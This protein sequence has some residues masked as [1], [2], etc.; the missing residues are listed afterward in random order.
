MT[1]IA[2]HIDDPPQIFFWEVD[3]FVVFGSCFTLGIM[4]GTPTVMILTGIVLAYLL[5]RVKA[6]RSDGFFLHI[7]YWYAGLPL[8]GCPP[9]YHR[10]FIE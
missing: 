4:S 2:R 5:A 6:G 3:E 7:L 10:T 1:R 9:S 8:K